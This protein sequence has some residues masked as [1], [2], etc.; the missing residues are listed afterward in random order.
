MAFISIDKLKG[1]EAEL[2]TCQASEAKSKSI[3]IEWVSD[4]GVKKV[5]VAC[6]AVLPCVLAH[7]YAVQVNLHYVTCKL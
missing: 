2:H 3:H 7:K 1:A 4:F 6:L 5:R